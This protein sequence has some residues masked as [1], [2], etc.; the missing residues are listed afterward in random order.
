M[1]LGKCISGFNKTRHLGYINY[2]TWKVEKP[3]LP[4]V[5]LSCP[6]S[7]PPFG[8]VAPSIFHYRCINLLWFS[9]FFGGV[10]GREWSPSWWFF[11]RPIWKICSSNGIISPILGV[12]VKD[13]W[14]QRQHLVR[15]HGSLPQIDMLRQYLETC[16][17]PNKD[18]HFELPPP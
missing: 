4:C 14:N 18:V 15:H 5:G 6:L 8:V 9:C 13:I 17:P 7:K 2:T 12:K 16:T 10:Q 1:N 3:Q 11:H